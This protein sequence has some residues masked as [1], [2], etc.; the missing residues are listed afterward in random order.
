MDFGPASRVAEIQIHA[1]LH[2]AP[3]HSKMTNDLLDVENTERKTLKTEESMPVH[4]H[5]RIVMYMSLRF[6]S[7]LLSWGLEIQIIW[8]SLAVFI[9]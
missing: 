2:W 1:L 7:E 8:S 4:S 5:S 3:K 6:C 9:H